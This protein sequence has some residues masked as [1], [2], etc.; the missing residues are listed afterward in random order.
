MDVASPSATY[1]EETMPPSDY[2]RDRMK[3]YVNTTT[4]ILFFEQKFLI[5]RL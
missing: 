1:L 3:N 4:F 2:V 5:I